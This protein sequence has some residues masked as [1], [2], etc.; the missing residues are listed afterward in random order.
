[1]EHHS[2][3]YVFMSQRRN[4]AGA[5]VIIQVLSPCN[6][7]EL[8][9]QLD[10]FNATFDDC[11]IARRISPV[12]NN[13]I[14]Q[15]VQFETSLNCCIAVQLLVCRCTGSPRYVFCEPPVQFIVL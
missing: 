4:L 5:L 14:P 6:T 12:V 10:S 9:K 3:I 8:N 2:Y 11:D 13:L 15:A 1:M 7:D